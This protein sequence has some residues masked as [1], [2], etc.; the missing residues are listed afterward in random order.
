LFNLFQTF[1]SFKV[2][3]ATMTVGYNKLTLHFDGRLFKTQ[4]QRIDKK[5]SHFMK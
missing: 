3:F 2:I 4:T 5:N 1:K